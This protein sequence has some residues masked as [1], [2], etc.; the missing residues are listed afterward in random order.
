MTGKSDSAKK[1][2]EASQSSKSMRETMV[3]GANTPA[4]SVG[5]IT[6][7]TY[8][9]AAL[10]GVSQ[11]KAVRNAV[12]IVF[13]LEARGRIGIFCNRHISGAVIQDSDETGIEAI[14]KLLAVQSGIFGFRVCL[15]D[16]GKELKQGLAIDIAELRALNAESRGKY[17]TPAVAVIQESNSQVNAEMTRV[18]F[19]EGSAE[20]PDFGGSLFG[21]SSIY[22]AEAAGD[23]LIPQDTNLD[24]QEPVQASLPSSSE[25]L[26]YLDFLYSSSESEPRMPTLGHILMP[27]LPPAAP[28]MA[29][30]GAP[31][32]S[33]QAYQRLVQD[34]L[35]KVAQHVERSQAD[36]AGQSV[37][38]DN[39]MDDLR[40]FTELLQSERNRVEKWSASQLDEL[41]TP[42]SVGEQAAGASG[43][44]FS[45]SK[46]STECEDLVTG[47]L[48]ASQDA[49]KFIQPTVEDLVDK[50]EAKHIRRHQILMFVVGTVL[51][52]TVCAVGAFTY[53]LFEQDK[54]VSDGIAQMKAGKPDVAVEK[55]SL[56]LADNPKDGRTFFHRAIAYAQNGEPQKALP[57]LTAALELG[58]PKSQVLTMR[59]S[60]E[61]SMR[62]YDRA[63]KDCNTAILDN[64]QD[65]QAYQ[66]RVLVH[67][68]LHQFDS[69]VEDS[70]C[71]LG[72]CHDTDTRAKLLQQR[73]FAES[74][75]HNWP[76]AVKD[77]TT[78]IALQPSALAYMQRA[79][80]YRA[81][82]S[83]PKAIEDY[84]QVIKLDPQSYDAYVARGVCSA[85][86]QRY[87]AAL[88]DFDKA[89]N[90]NPK[91]SAALMQRGSLHL[92]RKEWQQAVDDLQRAADLNPDVVELHDK[93]EVAVDQLK[94]NSKLGVVAKASIDGA[95]PG[96][97]P[98]L[99]TDV[100]AL[101]SMGYKYLTD[102]NAQDAIVC[103]A[104]AIRKQPGN[105]QAR[106][107]L[108]YALAQHNDYASAAAQLR[109]LSKVRPLDDKDMLHLGLWL[110][111]SNQVEGSIDVLA[112]LIE[113]SPQFLQAKAQL[114]QIYSD[115]GFP[116]KARLLCND[117]MSRSKTAEERQ[118]F[119]PLLRTLGA[120]NGDN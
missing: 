88:A 111:K 13:S 27:A 35:G 62:D 116:H 28:F 56:A 76:G 26:S 83:E 107:Y 99:P 9:W 73:S 96:A 119:E 112:H 92:D 38:R 75:L 93:L 52:M 68:R 50:D 86:L 60:V 34:E 3:E 114:A 89:V 94:R 115:Y 117:G 71:A 72:L 4:L 120:D 10:A 82:Y 100:G 5:N 7:P 2:T 84:D 69:A 41:A 11:A 36:V 14:K 77:L 43:G 44:R 37:G 66:V 20:T 109:A 23:Q 32:D 45:S 1:S 16:E 59:A 105:D 54:L 79:D 65:L 67:T 31:E 118:L 103:F 102:D 90:V 24:E 40:L 53:A 91:G 49:K 21:G 81:M 104:E 80:A 101:I 57:D 55:F 18:H 85:T 15:A 95:T 78:T 25:P 46:F 6:G 51:L 64:P 29:S 30:E 61:E 108:A 12:L 98:T 74:V 63:L 22:T 39:I 19:S 48:A 47:N 17:L 110:E 33:L 58:Q 42:S 106:K 113:R 87:D 97:T 70:T 8:L